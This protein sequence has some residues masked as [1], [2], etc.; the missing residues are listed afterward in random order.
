MIE[1]S[2]VVMALCGMA[3]SYLGGRYHAPLNR[4]F[5]TPIKKT[6]KE[7]SVHLCARCG[8]PVPA[9]AIKYHTGE[10]IHTNCK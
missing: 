5:R 1:A 2:E 9:D 6:S 3:L 4:I 8:E 7:F 10:W